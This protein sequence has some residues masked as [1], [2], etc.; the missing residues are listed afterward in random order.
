M[1]HPNNIFLTGFS[2]SGK[3]TVGRIAARLLGWAFVDLDEEIERAAG[4][5]IEE[6]FARHGEPHFRRLESEALAAACERDR[7]VVSTGGGIVVDWRNRRAMER[8]GVVVCLEARP[9]TLHARARA[10]G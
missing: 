10:P 4:S 8:G 7:Q 6:I 2:G 5:T 1:R 9:E 3:T